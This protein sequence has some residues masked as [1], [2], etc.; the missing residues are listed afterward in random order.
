MT[1]G[2]LIMPIQKIVILGL[3]MQGQAA[4]YDLVCNTDAQQLITADSRPD[5]DSIL[6]HFPGNRVKGVRIDGSN[7]TELASVMEGADMVIEALPGVMALSAGQVA[8]EAGVNL[9]SSMYY[10]NPGEQDAARIQAMKDEVARIDGEAK[11]KGITILTEFGL[12]PG[13]D[14]V[15]GAKVLSEFDD[16][17]EFHSYGTGLPVPEAADNP[18]KYKFSWSAIGVMRAYMRPAWVIRNGQVVEIPARE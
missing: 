14:L 5:M 7:K 18:L 13:I 1:A 9:V 2:V 15:M 3:G 11:E 17:E 8:S 12:D 16:V 6:T 4:L 10:I